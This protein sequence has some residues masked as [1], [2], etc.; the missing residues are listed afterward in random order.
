[1]GVDHVVHVVPVGSHGLGVAQL[2]VEEDALL[3]EDVPGDPDLPPVP[4]LDHDMVVP[5]GLLQATAVLVSSVSLLSVSKVTSHGGYA[6][7][8]SQ[9]CLTCRSLEE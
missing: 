2:A 5:P 1:M 4:G 8:D 7:C 9:L 6:I 3:A